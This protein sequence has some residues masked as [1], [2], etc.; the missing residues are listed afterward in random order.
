MDFTVSFLSPITPTSS[1]RQSIPASYISITAR[2]HFDVD[3]Y[4]DVDG[5]WVTGDDNNKLT[6]HMDDVN[7]DDTVTLRSWKIQK[8]DDQPFVEDN[9]RAE[10]G[11]L[12]FTGP[13]VR[14]ILLVIC[15]F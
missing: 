1:M 5:R 15:L 4:M 7:V 14:I 12:Q 10:W 3:V 13:S 8:Q 11:H 9:D 6:W 2:G